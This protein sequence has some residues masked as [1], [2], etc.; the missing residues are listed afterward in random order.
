MI[1]A[2]IVDLVHFDS[3]CWRRVYHTHV[4]GVL[5]CQISMRNSVMSMFLAQG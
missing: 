5:V 1:K 2:W 3:P 4:V